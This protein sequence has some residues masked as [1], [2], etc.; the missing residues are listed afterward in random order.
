MKQLLAGNTI[1]CKLIFYI[2][3]HAKVI[4]SSNIEMWVLKEEMEVEYDYEEKEK[5]CTGRGGVM[6][7][8]MQQAG[9]QNT[10]IV[11]KS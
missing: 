10:P 3:A 2:I 4:A 1:A 9:K 6:G 5:G 8:V 11:K 7:E